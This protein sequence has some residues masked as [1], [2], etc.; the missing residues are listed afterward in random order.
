[1]NSKYENIIN[2]KHH[3]LIYHPRM[4]IYNR[5][6]QFAPFDALEGYSDLV[7]ETARLTSKRIVIDEELKLILNNKLNKIEDNISL[8][9]ECMF[10]YFI[11]D[12]TKSGGEYKE[13]IGNVKKIDKYEKQ[14][15]LT[16]KIKI[17]IND[18]IDISFIE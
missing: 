3:D 13:I 4:S 2:I 9:P 11:K 7:K 8:S 6:A 17:P 15:I 5:S 1:M 16:N 18:I 10:T 14:V 12:K